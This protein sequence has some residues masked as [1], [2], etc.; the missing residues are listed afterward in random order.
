MRLIFLCVLLIS[1]VDASS[2][3]D[4]GPYPT[5][6]HYAVSYVQNSAVLSRTDFDALVA[7]RTA[8]KEWAYCVGAL[9]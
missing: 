7:E 3:A 2:P 4:C 9:Q 5:H 8:A 1:C 6:G